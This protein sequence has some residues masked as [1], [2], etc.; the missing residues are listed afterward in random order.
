MIA[1]RSRLFAA[2]LTVLVLTPALAVSGVAVAQETPTATPAGQTDPQQMPPAVVVDPGETAPV[3]GEDLEGEEGTPQPPVIVMA[4]P[5]EPPIPAIWSPVPLDDQGRSAYGLYLAGKLALMNGEGETG[6]AYLARAHALVP[7]QPRLSGQVF[8]S[9]MLAGDLDVAAALTP[10]PGEAPPALVEAGRLTQAVRDLARGDPA[11]ANAMLAAQPIGTPHAR[12]GLMVS[13]WIAASAGDWDRALQAPPASADPLSRAF[14]GLNRALLLEHRGDLAEAETTLKALSETAGIGPIFRRPYGEFL[15][16][17]GRRDE[18]R[19]VYETAAT[20]DTVDLPTLRALQRVR[21]GG[22]A[23]AAPTFAQGAAEALSNAAALASAERGHEFAAV[24][25]RLAQSLDPTASGQIQLAQALSRAGLDSASRDALTRVGTEDPVLYAN[26]R[27]QLALALSEDGQGE[28]A[29]AELRR[30]AAAAPNDRRVALFTAN[31]LMALERY[32]EA[33]VLL[34]GPLLN[35]ADQDV[36][37]RFLR[38]AAYES[39]GRIPEAEAELWAALQADPDNADT[40]NYLGYLWVDRGLRVHQG[41]EMLA[42]AHAAEPDNGNIQDSL[43]W[44][45]YRQGLYVDA[46][47]SLE[48]AVLKEPGNAE[49]N[50]HLGD[51]Y[52]RVGRQREAGFQWRRVLTLDPEAERRTEVERKLENGL[53]DEPP[54]VGVSQ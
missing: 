5:A 49:I 6:A 31:Q 17:R 33:L 52:W 12:A 54:A 51:A 40:L 48:A 1:S 30:A 26:A 18:A 4:D 23:P 50:D 22:R 3:P 53:G 15:E 43:G 37:V 41:A 20:T 25:L 19:A 36:Q 9:A 14:A 44:A 39:L 2:S 45:Q 11:T 10:A 27:V 29:L 35:T 42:R 8:T 28:E 47:A 32:E 34:D 13:P 7:E 21:Q 16:R 38:G 46:V 24:Y